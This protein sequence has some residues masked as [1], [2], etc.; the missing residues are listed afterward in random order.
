M[1]IRGRKLGRPGGTTAPCHGRP[2][3]FIFDGFS[4][5]YGLFSSFQGAADMFDSSVEH[6]QPKAF[7]DGPLNQ[8]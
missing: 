8:V 6:R 5:R 1:N 7:L 3:G 2:Y 4:R